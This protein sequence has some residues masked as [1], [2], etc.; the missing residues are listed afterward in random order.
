MLEKI[1]NNTNTVCAKTQ[2]AFNNVTNFKSCHKQEKEEHVGLP[3][4]STSLAIFNASELAR[5]AFAGEI[6]KI[7]QFSLLMN[8]SSMFRICISMSGG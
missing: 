1:K 5:S 4:G 2:Q 8:S 7:K 3:C 6:A